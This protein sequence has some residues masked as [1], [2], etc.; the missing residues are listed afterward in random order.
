MAELVPAYRA[1][2]SI[3]AS[4][5][6]A[7][8]DALMSKFWGQ[9]GAQTPFFMFLYERIYDLPEDTSKLREVAKSIDHG[10]VQAIVGATLNNLHLAYPAA[11]ATRICIFAGNPENEGVNRA[12]GGV[13]GFVPGPGLMLL[14]LNPIEGWQQQLQYV[15]AHE[16]HH[17]AWFSHVYDSSE[18]LTLLY[19]MILEGRADHFAER[20]SRSGRKQWW[21]QSLDAKAEVETWVAMQPVLHS[22]GSDLIRRYLFGDG[23]SVPWL[24]GYQIGYKIVEAF[25]Q[26]HPELGVAEWTALDAEEILR[27]S[28]YA[29]SSK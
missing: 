5:A 4:T 11:Q 6:E 24:A 10:Q 9:C 23:K 29:P 7:F 25:L 27:R 19:R 28:G 17:A 20:F 16:Y 3:E 15:L 2:A 22:K 12:L 18:P 26:K 8:G 13:N 1:A 21:T 14:N